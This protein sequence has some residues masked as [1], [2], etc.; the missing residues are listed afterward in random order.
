MR[1][2]GG[3]VGKLLWL[4]VVATQPAFADTENPALSSQRRQLPNDVEQ[5]ASYCLAVVK[6]Q[7]S[8]FA[9][10]ADENEKII[11]TITDPATK[12]IFND[13][14][15]NLKEEIEQINDNINRLKLF[16]LPRLSYL[17]PS[18]MLSASSRGEAD[19]YKQDGSQNQTLLKQCRDRCKNNENG[20]ACGI[21]CAEEYP[22]NRRIF[23]CRDLSFLPY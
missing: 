6:L 1:I 14:A 16:L 8:A 18:A 3:I 19:F 7:H 17:D 13:S 4:M 20:G 23:Q 5:K 21:A 11:P 22:L 12:K 15:Q 2:S 9:S 10:L